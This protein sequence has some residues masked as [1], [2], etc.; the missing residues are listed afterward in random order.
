MCV[1]RLICY[2]LS[3]LWPGTVHTWCE[4]SA[5]ARQGAWLRSSSVIHTVPGRGTLHV[6]DH[7]AR[8]RAGVAECECTPSDTVAGE[9]GSLN[10]SAARQRPDVIRPT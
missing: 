1:L 4:R 3:S 9:T 7:E 10:D 2:T 6:V 8:T 5:R